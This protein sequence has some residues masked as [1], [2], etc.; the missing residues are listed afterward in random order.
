MKSITF[1]ETKWKLVP[2]EPTSLMLYVMH[3]NEEEGFCAM[4]DAALHAAPQPD[5]CA[6]PQQVDVEPVAVV[7]PKAYHGLRWEKM[8][9]QLP[10]GTGLFIHPDPEV[11]KLRSQLAVARQAIDNYLAAN[12]PSEFGCACDPDV[13]Y[14]CGPCYE[15][16]RQYPLRKALG[17]LGECDGTRLC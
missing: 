10:T 14:L 1:D 2:I 12:D 17:Q 8:L 5:P 11:A 4:Y 16:K 9:S 3:H 15:N 13:G 6:L 7:D